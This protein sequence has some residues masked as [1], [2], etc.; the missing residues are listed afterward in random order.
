MS[1]KWETRPDGTRYGTNVRPS[2]TTQ[3]RKEKRRLVADDRARKQ[4]AR[5]NQ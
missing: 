5:E 3:R 2:R 4:A 1:R